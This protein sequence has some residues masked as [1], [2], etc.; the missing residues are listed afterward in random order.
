VGYSTDAFQEVEAKTADL[1][2]ETG[3]AVGI[4]IVRPAMP[5]RLPPISRRT[6]SGARITIGRVEVQINNQLPASPTPV[7]A[8][9]TGK[10]RQ[11]NLQKRFL[12]RFTL[13]P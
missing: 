5:S 2:P 8:A 3:S 10:N 7:P 12:D 9:K 13:R 6:E 4:P 1:A 11:D